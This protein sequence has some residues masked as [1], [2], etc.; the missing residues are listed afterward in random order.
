M[1]KILDFWAPWCGPCQAMKSVIEELEKELKGKAEFLKINVDEKGAE[2]AKYGVMSIPT[3]IVLRDSKEVAR[4]MG[5]CTKAEFLKL[6][7]VK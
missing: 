4:K 6:I 3:I 5:V 1:L 7:D 2:A